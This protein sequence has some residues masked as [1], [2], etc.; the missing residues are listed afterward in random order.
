[1]VLDGSR[2]QRF[3]VSRQGKTRGGVFRRHGKEKRKKKQTEGRTIARA[4]PAQ[5]VA[6]PVG[7]A[8]EGRQ[9]STARARYR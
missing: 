4:S 5:V 2:P 8:I 9:K 3:A 6:Y 1:V 7:S